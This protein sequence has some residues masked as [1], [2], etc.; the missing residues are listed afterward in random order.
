[1]C[2]VVSRASHARARLAA[3]EV[4]LAQQRGEALLE[5]LRPA[6]RGKTDENPVQNRGISGAEPT[7]PQAKGQ[8]RKQK[9]AHRVSASPCAFA[10]SSSSAAFASASLRVFSSLFFE[11]RSALSR[12]RACCAASF[13]PSRASRSSDSSSATRAPASRAAS[14]APRRACSERETSAWIAAGVGWWWE[15]VE[16]PTGGVSV[17]RF[18]ASRKQH[19]GRS[20]FSLSLFPRP[21]ACELLLRLPQALLQV[22]LALR[23]APFLRGGKLAAELVQAGPGGQGR[24]RTDRW[25]GG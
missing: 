12:S 4:V 10:A 5:A 21:R 18:R 22:A 8:T 9:R 24:T 19:E 6:V 23:G 13:A 2:V 15:G 20:R 3:L 17:R 14:E 1:M 16:G 7:R 11:S 25:T